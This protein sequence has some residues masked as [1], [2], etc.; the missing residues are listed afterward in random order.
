MLREVII[1]IEAR[2]GS[3]W[4]EDVDFGHRFLVKPYSEVALPA[5]MVVLRDP[6]HRSP[7]L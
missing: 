2:T 4:V 1:K 5:E 3:A 7:S 6:F